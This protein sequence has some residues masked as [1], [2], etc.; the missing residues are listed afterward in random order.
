MEE[1]MKILHFIQTTVGIWIDHWSIFV[2]SRSR[3]DVY[4]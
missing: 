3:I 1:N 4:D 2:T